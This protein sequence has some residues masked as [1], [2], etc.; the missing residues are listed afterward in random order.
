[1]SVIEG[2]N[3]T[4]LR[5]K[6]DLGKDELTNKTK[7]KSKTYSNIKPE[8]T[9]QAIYDVATALEGL[10]EFPVNVL[11]LERTFCEKI[12]S[13]VRFSYSEDYIAD[14]KSKIRHT[15]DLHQMLQQKEILDFFESEDF[16]KMLNKVGQDDVASYKNDNE[17]LKFHPKD[18][19]FFAKLDEIWEQLEQTYKTDFRN[20]VY[21]ELP[22][23][24]KVKLSLERLKYRI[25]QIVWS[26]EV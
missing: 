23:S 3:P 13:L 24:G 4:S 14:L 25:E 10:Q 16:E 6:F 7:V 12:M 19:R 21:G 1:M 20:L 8:A 2:K 5:M 9:S 26:V 17:W 15:Y 22:D 18:S 11:K